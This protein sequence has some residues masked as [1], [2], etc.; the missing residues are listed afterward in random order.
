M[1]LDVEIYGNSSGDY[2]GRSV[3][4]AGDFN[5]DG[6]ADVIVGAEGDDDGGSSSG[7]AYIFAGDSQ[8]S[9]NV[10]AYEARVRLVG[11]DSADYFGCSVGGGR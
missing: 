3:S 4:G 8:F 11:R 7:C 2:L 5:G 9:Q 10:R 6:Y 1:A